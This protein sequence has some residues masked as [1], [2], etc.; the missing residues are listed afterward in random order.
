M[1]LK[2]MIPDNRFSDK[3]LLYRK[4][5]LYELHYFKCTVGRSGPFKCY[6]VSCLKC[7]YL[8]HV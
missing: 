4:N 7:I 2:S 6:G 3:D 8:L 1:A 5:E